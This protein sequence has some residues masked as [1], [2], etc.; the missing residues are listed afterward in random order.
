MWSLDGKQIPKSPGDA[1][2]KHPW[3]TTEGLWIKESAGRKCT[4]WASSSSPN[5]CNGTSP[6]R[7][8]PFQFMRMI[9]WAKSSNLKKCFGILPL[10]RIIFV[11]YFLFFYAFPNSFVIVVNLWSLLKT[12]FDILC[13][14]LHEIFEHF[15]PLP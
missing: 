6:V 9:S 2:H 12:N 13:L 8:F 5:Y 10:S 4:G 3:E 14:I 7:T 1:R 15:H 11:E